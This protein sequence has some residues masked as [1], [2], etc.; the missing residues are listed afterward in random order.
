MPEL[1]THS[2]VLSESI[3]LLSKKTDKTPYTRPL[4]ILFNNSTF[5][6]AAL[7]G[8]FGP[9]IF[10]YIPSLKSDSFGHPLSKILHS[11]KVSESI[12]Y[13]INNH[14]KKTT[15]LNEWNA[16]QKSYLLGYL[17]HL[18]T[19]A[20]FN[21]FIFYRAGFP[22]GRDKQSI[23]YYREQ[24]LL[25]CYNIDLFF[26][27]LFEGIKYPFNLGN[28][29]LVDKIFL[30]RKIKA[31]IKVLLLSMI[32]ALH[33]E[34]SQ[35][36]DIDYQYLHTLLRSFDRNSVLSPIDLLPY[37]I[38][39]QY[40]IKRSSS[41]ILKKILNIIRRRKLLFPDYYLPY[42]EPRRINRHILN[43]HREQWVYPAFSTGLHYESVEDLFKI[44][45]SRTVEVWEKIEGLAG[46]RKDE[47][48]LLRLLS[49][50]AYTGEYNMHP[51]KMHNKN[52]QRIQ[53]K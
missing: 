30:S 2:R 47:A 5:K 14:F 38:R 41:S 22:D 44:A 43:L 16:I 6:T 26:Q 46:N 19:D 20:L 33:C 53:F 23:N 42:P 28:H 25:H 21:P 36:N 15:A 40:G 29:L 50:D 31:P 3:I 39:L 7:F 1:I 45:R 17:C 8:S 35:I 51:D 37:L 10:N 11:T 34:T 32:N 18:I 48:A 27:Y 52:H 49:I 13:I 9:D 4:Q 12:S 24:Y